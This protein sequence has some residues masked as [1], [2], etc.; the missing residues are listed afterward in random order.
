[1]PKQPEAPPPLC[2]PSGAPSPTPPP[3]EPPPAPTL[4]RSLET[5]GRTSGW[6]SGI[7]RRIDWRI[8]CVVLVVGLSLLIWRTVG[9]H[10]RTEPSPVPA[11]EALPVP[12]ARVTRQDL[13]NKVTFPAEFRPYLEVELHAKV[14]GY[15]R[16]MK[17][18][19][20]DRV[21]AGQLLARLEVPE[22]RDELNQAIAAQQRA[23]AEYA[24]AHTN[25]TRLLGVVKEHPNLVAQQDL[26]NA[27]AKDESTAA[28][29]GMAKAEAGKYHTLLDYT[30]ITAPF[31]GV[32]TKRY[33]D[34]GTLIQ[35]GTASDT[36]SLPL[37]RVSD[38]Y[39][40]R[41]DFPVDQPYVKDV[42]VGDSLEVR[43]DSLGGETFT[44][45]ITRCTFR[46]DES[47]RTMLTEIEVPNPELKIVPG[48]YCC[49]VLK[50]G[51]RPRAFAIPTEAVAADEKPTVLVVNSKQEI[52]ERKVVLGLETPTKHEVLSGL[53]EGDLVLVGDRSKVKPGQKVEP[54]LVESLAQQ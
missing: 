9:A 23:E 52:E 34:P 45:T 33:A 42:H 51:L 38:N 14:S 29:I 22:L 32:I 1:M 36:Q 2:V 37:V 7:V 21:K 40:L 18:D 11:V 8:L 46:E 13:Y 54:K 27:E 44:G 5:L 39:L 43:V 26:D 53:N 19:F 20:G 16:E 15:V 17:V 4:Q 49:V 35:A 30:Q 47:T 10:V 28:A 50:P 6:L 31:D 24:D 12:V 25:Y 3:A 41:L 48:M